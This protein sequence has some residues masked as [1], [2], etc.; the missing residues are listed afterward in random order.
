M[1]VRYTASA[2]G[3]CRNLRCGKLV[4]TYPYRTPFPT[5]AAAVA[6]VYVHGQLCVSLN[7]LYTGARLDPI[8]VPPGT[9][10]GTG[11]VCINNTCHPHSVLGY[12]CNSKVKCHGHG[13]CNNKKQCHCH[14][15][16]KPPDC[17]KRGSRLGGSIDSG[18]QLSDGGLSMARVMEDVTTAWPVLGS[19]LLLLLLAGAICLVI[20]WWAMGLCGPRPPSTDSA[21]TG[22][23]TDVSDWNSVM[24]LELDTDKEQSAGSPRSR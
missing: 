4:C 12:D 3:F 24:G 6:Y 18:L 22:D 15:G 11:K 2:N 23:S 9:K 16:W 14:P 17:L 10:C 1:R 7:Y 13:V 21:V 8:L 5:D 20:R 19:C